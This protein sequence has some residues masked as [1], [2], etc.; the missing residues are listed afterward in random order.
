MSGPAFAPRLMPHSLTNQ[1]RTAP[2]RHQYG[3]LAVR[4]GVLAHSPS[5]STRAGGALHRSHSDV[6]SM[7]NMQLNVVAE[8]LP[9]ACMDAHADMT[10]GSSD[11]GDSRRLRQLESEGQGVRQ[12]PRIKQEQLQKQHSR[13]PPTCARA[14]AAPS[15]VLEH[16][17]VN[18]PAQTINGV[19]P[20]LCHD[21]GTQ[22]DDVACAG[23][24]P[25]ATSSSTAEAEL[26]WR[27]QPAHI[28]LAM[29]LVRARR[30]QT[31]TQWELG[32]ARAHV[33]SLQAQI[34]AA[35]AAALAAAAANLIA[36]AEA[37]DTSEPQTEAEVE[38]KV[39]AEGEEENDEAESGVVEAGVSEGASAEDGE[40][41]GGEA[42]LGEAEGG[43]AKGDEVQGGEAEGTNASTTGLEVAETETSDAEMAEAEAC[44]P[45][46]VAESE[47][48]PA[49]PSLASLKSLPDAAAGSAVAEGAD[50]MVL[51]ECLLVFSGEDATR[52][53]ICAQ[54]AERTGGSHVTVIDVMSHADRPPSEAALMKFTT[55]LEALLA[56]MRSRPPPY[57]LEMIPT[58]PTQLAKLEAAVGR[59]PIA[60]ATPGQPSIGG[61]VRADTQFRGRLGKRVYTMEDDSEAAVTAAINAMQAAGLSVHPCKESTRAT[62]EVDAEPTGGVPAHSMLQTPAP[63]VMA[64]NAGTAEVEAVTKPQEVQAGSTKAETAEAE[65]AEAEAAVTEAAV[66]EVADAEPAA[67]TAAATTAEATTAEAATAEAATAE[68]ATVEA[69]TAEVATAEVAEGPSP[70]YLTEKVVQPPKEHP[71]AP[72]SP[73]TASLTGAHFDLDVGL[74]AVVETW[75]PHLSEPSD[76]HALY[77]DPVASQLRERVERI[78][79]S[80]QLL[81]KLE[82]MPLLTSPQAPESHSAVAGTDPAGLQ[83]AEPF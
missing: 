48:A 29:Q 39:G 6:S 24:G 45:E 81:L 60:I 21:R 1:H 37:L 34:D 16:I 40:A 67:A 18:A 76:E 36:T 47:I 23:T 65:A 52:R 58:V 44:A 54:L 49:P 70:E 3:Y 22:V 43:D 14:L 56:L 50:A 15:P 27:W 55:L 31:A 68:A 80:E 72:P 73:L 74:S 8:L 66:A 13:P 82:R 35:A 11:D 79:S 10:G 12:L 4:Q 38:E 69:L 57:V 63:S 5:R 9:P 46:A 41:E 71:A 61:G 32:Q 7:P 19:A 2:A 42:E 30:Q 83:T 78:Q 33:E 53:S 28:R 64:D 17:H 77:E 26:R 59:L 20:V 25:E 75:R 62:L 51:S